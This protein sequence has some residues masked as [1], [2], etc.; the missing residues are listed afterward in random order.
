MKKII[1]LGLLFFKVLIIQAQQKT[2]ISRTG[3]KVEVNAEAS[4]STK[5][6]IRLAGDLAGS[7]T[8]PV[9][10]DGVITDAK[11]AGSISVAK[12][13]TG[14]TTFSN[15]ELLI[16]NSTG[17]T[18]TKTTLTG[19]TD[20]VNVTNGPGTIALSLPQSIAPTSIVNFNS[21]TLNSTGADTPAIRFKPNS[22]FSIRDNNVDTQFL[23]PKADNNS[24]YL[25]FPAEGNFFVRNEFDLGTDN[26]SF[27]INSSGEM[28]LRSTPPDTDDSNRVAT[29][30][31][32]KSNAALDATTTA[33]G[34]IR[35]AGDLA[36]TATDPKVATGA[37]DAN[38][39]ATGAVN[40]ASTKVTGLLPGANGGTGVNN[41]GKTITLGGNLT[42]SGNF[43]TT[44]TTTAATS[45]TL[46]T[47]GTLATLSGTETLT[48]KILTSP[49]LQ[50]RPTAPTAPTQT[51]DEQIATTAFVKNAL[52][53][54]TGIY[55][56]SGSLSG[57]T[58][59]TQGGNTLAFNS[60]AQNGFSINSTSGA[61]NFSV[62]TTNGFV[63]VGTNNPLVGKFVL[64]SINETQIAITKTSIATGWIG[65]KG[66]LGN[67]EFALGSQGTTP[68][69]FRTNA[70]YTNDVNAT[71]ISSTASEVRL[72]ID[73]ERGYTGIGNF[74]DYRPFS[75]LHLNLFKDGGGA[76]LNTTR[77]I[78]AI[79][80][81]RGVSSAYFG[82]QG[83]NYIHSAQHNIIFKTASNFPELFSLT[84]GSDNGI[85]SGVERLKI[86]REG[87]ISMFPH[88]ANTTFPTLTVNFA[89]TG[90]I[91]TVGNNDTVSGIRMIDNGSGTV[92][93]GSGIPYIHF[94]SNSSPIGFIGRNSS[95]AISTFNVSDYRLKQ[96]LKDFDAL[97]ILNQIPIYDFEWKEFKTRSYGVMAHELQA[98]LPK[99][100]TGAKDA[101]N[102]DGTIDTQQVDYN[103]LLP[104]TVK[105]VQEVDKKVVE[106]QRLN[107]A[108][109][110]RVTALEKAVQELQSLIN[111]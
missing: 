21:L 49:A 57:N 53:A 12:G 24:T 100:V 42:T 11:I 39:L 79:I 109:E 85:T 89:G 48:N 50:E 40:L 5:G 31:F 15:G 72:K 34:K 4:A 27:K 83:F 97:N 111:K 36:G 90:G 80:E 3:E 64:E 98:V 26:F 69:V 6:I 86:E 102:A 55:K 107:T 94:F 73:G 10:K 95:F 82:I 45:V 41:T 23:I 43:A 106:L 58:T 54:G 2:V 52:T 13:G 74:N 91:N 35:L 81:N 71:G 87:S 110:Q 18:L 59:V 30:A 62:N 66:D 75:L 33:T 84:Q 20:Q 70:E 1:F 101:V 47:T 92:G 8:E 7:A 44:L 51:N 104:I 93:S 38:K 96:D 17:N 56:G 63:G 37:I 46:P 78:Q 61:S 28:T 19:T 60:S 105:A 65:V 76:T 25:T 9:V 32:V 103:Y 16:G 29:T 22:Y 68:I 14:Q 99:A 77:N 88:S 108:L 67:R